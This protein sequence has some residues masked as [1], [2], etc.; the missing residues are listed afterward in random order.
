M[1]E[2]GK[3]CQYLNSSKYNLLPYFRYLHLVIKDVQYAK[4]NFHNFKETSSLLIMV[5]ILPLFN[6]DVEIKPYNR[7]YIEKKNL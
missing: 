1:I 4:Q 2:L 6:S 7:V 3:L 5:Y